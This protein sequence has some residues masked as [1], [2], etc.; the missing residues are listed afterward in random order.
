MPQRIVFILSTSRTG[1]KA[2]A[3]GLACD[4][5]I[6][7]HQPPFSRLLTIASNYYLHGWLPEWFIKNLIF[8]IR[9]PQIA[10]ASRRY[11]I[12]VFSLDHIPAKYLYDKH[13][14]MSIIHIVR[15]AR[16]FVPSYLNWMRT[17]TKSFIANKFVPGWHPSGF[18]TGAIPFK[19]WVRMKPYQKVSWHWAYKNRFIENTFRESDRYIRIFFEEL[20]SEKGPHVL[21]E[22]LSRAGI[23]Y[24]NSFDK[25][26]ATKK[27]VSKKNA[28]PLWEKW[29]EKHKLELTRICGDLM[30]RYGYL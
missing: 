19:E 16:T 10:S 6:S 27:N 18:F 29:P 30:R 25:I 26:F 7:P 24:R 17:K 3:E 28:C 22:A 14:D 9:E 13:Q 8:L 23:P 5:V 4:D 11:Y 1:T 15:D 2:L 12:Q 21:E 20:F